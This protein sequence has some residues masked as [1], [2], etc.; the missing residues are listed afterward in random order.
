MSCQNRGQ[1]A[2]LRRDH[3][4]PRRPRP[5][6]PSVAGSGTAAVVTTVLYVPMVVCV[7]PGPVSR[8]TAIARALKVEPATLYERFLA[9]ERAGRAKG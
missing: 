8:F 2:S 6:K 5:S 4:I 7:T 3:P 1:R 9:W